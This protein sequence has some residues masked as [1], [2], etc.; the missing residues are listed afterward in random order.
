M[1]YSKITVRVWET[2]EEDVQVRGTVTFVREGG[3]PCANTK[4]SAPRIFPRRGK[5]GRGVSCKGRQQ[6]Q[7]ASS[8]QVLFAGVLKKKKGA[9]MLGWVS[10]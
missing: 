4:F 2:S 9:P 7:A 8:K 5:H 6:Q 3:S 1:E 10:W